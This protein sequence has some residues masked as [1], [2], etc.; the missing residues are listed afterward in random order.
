MK[1]IEQLGNAAKAKREQRPTPALLAFSLTAIF[2][3]AAQA[4]TA[5]GTGE[6]VPEVV[7]TAQRV[8]S[9][10]SKTPVA[11][12]VLSGAQLD[13]AGLDSPAGI[14][15]RLP[16]VYLDGAADGLR[17]TMRGV[18]NAD[19]TEKGDPSAAFLMDG[20]YIARP[21]GQNL[22]FYDLDRIEVLRGPQG[23]LYGRNTTAGVVNVISNAPTR[24]L[25]GAVGIG[26]GTANARQGSGMLNLPVNASLALRAALSFQRHDGF[27]RNTGNTPYA[28]GMDRDESAARLSAKLALG[29]DASLLVRYD[30]SVQRDNPDNFVP[31]TNFYGGLASGT[32]TWKDAST[33]ERLNNGFVPFNTRREQGHARKVNS[34]LGAELT[35][36]LGPITLSY[37]GAHRRFEHD[38][39][40]NFFYRVNPTVALGVHESFAGSYR[41]NSHE[42]RLANHG[43]GALQVQ[44][45]LYYFREQSYQYYTFRDLVLL[46]LPPYYVFPH[47]PTVARSQ[48]AFGQATYS[49]TPT[50]RATAGMRYTQDDK[51][52]LGSTNLQQGPVFNPATDQRLLNAADLSSHKTTWRLGLDYDLAPAALLYA[53]VATGYKA[54]G[55]N[56]GCLA[57]T[58]A[59]GMDCPP[60]S[61]VQPST[62][63][64]QPERLTSYEAGL[65]TRFWDTRATL[66]ASVFDYDYDN[67]QLSGVAIDHGAPRFVT[68]NAASASVR[69]LELDG[70]AA[71]SAQ[72]RLRYGA[73]W[74]DAHYVRYTPDG[75]HSWAGHKLDR[76]PDRVLSLGY[77]HS[78]L[79]PGARL[80]AGLSARRSAAFSIGVPMKLLEY[81]IPAHTA[82]DAVLEYLPANGSWSAQLQVKN[83]DNKVQP[84]AIDSFGMVVAS[85]PRTFDLR[86][87]YR[88]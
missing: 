37:L 80:T 50:L 71:L 17:I 68:T 23:T 73:T 13:K 16:N 60:Q 11:M 43:G 54:G 52:R 87:N 42:L 7:V 24:Q 74:L 56:D 3:G 31:D 12:S 82:A 59:M 6:Q 21:Q 4:Q 57:G 2:N 36:N 27:L 64:Y 34:G 15:A 14:G 81:R 5:A 45:G 67:L 70:Q 38:F 79:L 8:A 48:A 10:E 83:L 69:G 20:V 25:E 86:F 30:R 77:E 29:P 46:G 53:S 72:D 26:F 9:L 32:P 62:L 78:F 65:K 41:Q 88:F 55:F 40:T 84:I 19:T 44:G 51:S 58:R 75:V 63:Y 18:S 35:W 1:V 39:L 61:V 66:N 33:D 22:G 47:G 76:A 49:L 28:L 85:D